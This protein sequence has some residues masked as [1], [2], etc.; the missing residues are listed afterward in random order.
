[1]PT[2]DVPDA[3]YD[4]ALEHSNDALMALLDADRDTIRAWRKATGLHR[5][6]GRRTLPARQNWDR[7]MTVKDLARAHAWG[8]ERRFGEALRESRPDIHA[9]ARA[10]GITRRTAHNKGK[11]NG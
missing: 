1:M 3:F 4:L 8:S 6:R 7:T 2:D 11:S 10:N 5:P 9:Q